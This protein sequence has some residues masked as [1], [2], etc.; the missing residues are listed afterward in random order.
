MTKSKKSSPQQKT[1]EAM[2]QVKYKTDVQGLDD[3]LRG[4]FEL[5]PQEEAKNNASLLVLIKGASGTGKTTLSLQIACS[6]TKWPEKFHKDVLYFSCE[7]THQDIYFKCQQL[8]LQAKIPSGPNDVSPEAGIAV[9][10]ISSLSEVTGEQPFESLSSTL[11]RANGI[12]DKISKKKSRSRLIVVDGLNA[13]TQKERELLEI[14]RL[15]K[16]LR[17]KSLVSIIVFEEAHETDALDYLVDM[18]IEMTGNDAENESEYFINH[19]RISKSRYQQSAL[20]WHQYKIRGRKEGKKP[21]DDGQYLGV[22]VFPSLHFHVH[23]T[24]NHVHDEMMRSCF[25]VVDPRVREEAVP[26]YIEDDASIISFLL[27]FGTTEHPV[28]K[29]GSST[30]ILGPRQTFKTQLTLDFLRAGYE[31]NESGLLLSLMDNPGDIRKERES[32]CKRYCLKEE[33]CADWSAC[34]KNVY[35]FHFRPGCISSSEFFQ[36][37][38]A[39]LDL[40]EKKEEDVPVKR[41]VLWDMTQIEYRFPLMKADEMFLP[42]L[43]DYLKYSKNRNGANRKITSVFMGAANTPL[44][45]A[46]STMADNVIFC[47]QDTLT[48]QNA[49]TIEKELFDGIDGIALYLDR[50]EGIPSESRIFFLKMREKKNSAYVDIDTRTKKQLEERITL[51]KDLQNLLNAQD[52]IEQI[53]RKHGFVTSMDLKLK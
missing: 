50:I 12:F 34:Y 11:T 17:Q 41:L 46:A 43:M 6:A 27:N 33:R 3:I 25:S 39:R 42:A 5:P 30:A 45:A 28:F 7:Q 48:R 53:R 23:K 51:V 31:K 18:V 4:G 14:Q 15:L 10:D 9:Q 38:E 40:S 24:P 35:N 2:S 37:M 29:R 26:E 16:L 20:G 19:L 8:A 49:V 21:K 32:L 52:P 22:E 1:K 36:K 13:L 44:A 47:W